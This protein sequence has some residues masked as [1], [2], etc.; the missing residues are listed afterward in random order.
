MELKFDIRVA[1]AYSSPSQKIKALT[2]HWVNKQIYCPNCGKIDVNKYPN[3]RPV[4]DFF[5]SN[6]KEDYEL[7]S[8]QGKMGLKIVDGAYRTMIKRLQSANNPNFFLLNYNV[9]SLEVSDFFVI[10]K[11]FLVPNII[12]KRKPLSPNADRAGWVGCNIL[13]KSI[14]ETGKIFF[15]KNGVIETKNRVMSEWNKTLFL[16]EEQD[17]SAKGWLLDIMRCLDRIGKKTFAL[18][19]VYVF[20]KEL[21]QLHPNNHHIK[22]KIRQQLQVLR[23]KNYLMFI[24]SGKYQLN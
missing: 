18:S 5:C 20:E 23:D 13:I 10:P 1:K 3:N 2:E 4:A 14:P 11:H 17:I 22:D 9:R 15:I 12:E 21:S 7:K 6:C 16:K 24:S 19:D 8:K